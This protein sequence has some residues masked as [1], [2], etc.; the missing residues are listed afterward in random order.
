MLQRSRPDAEPRI[1]LYR[2]LARVADRTL[3][4][5]EVARSEVMPLPQIDALFSPFTGGVGRD[6]IELVRQPSDEVGELAL[7]SA[8][9][10]QSLDQPGALPIGLFEQPAEG[11]REATPTIFGRGLRKIRNR[12]QPFFGRDPP[13]RQAMN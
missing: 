13:W 7:P 9:L 6:R 12:S 3:D 2:G 11:E 1:E 10:R 8:H 5:L 4:L